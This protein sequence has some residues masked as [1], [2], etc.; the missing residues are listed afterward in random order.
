MN[1]TSSNQQMI[2]N[3][4]AAIVVFLVNALISFFL[5]PFI[6]KELGAEANGFVQLAM[7]FVSYI[8]IIMAA[9]NSMSS[10]FMTVAYHS[11]NYTKMNEYYSST[12]AGNN[13][14]ILILLVPV[15]LGIIFLEHLIQISPELVYQVKGLFFLVFVNYFASTGTPNWDVAFFAT[16]KIYLQS[17]G[18]ILSYVVRAITIIILYA[19]FPTEVWYVGL[20]SIFATLVLQIWLYMGMRREFPKV[21][22]RLKY[23]KISAIKDLVSSGIWNSVSQLGFTLSN[24]LNLLITNVFIGSTQM[25][26]VSLSMIVPTVITSLQLAVSNTFAPNLT[27][28]FTKRKIS[29]MV[30]EIYKAGKLTLI[31]IGLP[32]A[33]FI[34]FGKP[35]FQLWLPTQDASQLQIL[36]VLTMVNLV[37]INGSQALLQIFVV[38]NKNRPSA[39]SV[40]IGGVA[41]VL[42]T[43]L[44]LVTTNWGIYAVVGVSSIIS[45][46]R[47]LIFV[48]PFS[49]KYLG[50]EWYKFFPLVGYSVLTLIVNLIVGWI[51]SLF[52]VINSWMTLV[53]AAAI[54]AVIAGLV[55]SYIVFNKSERKYILSIISSRIR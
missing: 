16:N 46:L 41:T 36:S 33:G 25:G 32:L 9:L 44:A 8:A 54:F 24:G 1:K 35:F 11:K 17:I 31:I 2:I 37:L 48:I 5:S 28:L 6:V 13:I 43:L 21:K 22:F 19:F 14:I 38:I 53:I 47:Y 49:A 51:V 20:A 3:L 15:T 42:I 18:T 7:N 10:R 50:L 52:I 55:S 27:I 39:L 29:E 12:F 23:V 30:S 34:I 26:I 45:M 40:V 4:G